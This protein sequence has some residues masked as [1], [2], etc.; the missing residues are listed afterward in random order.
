MWSRLHTRLCHPT[1]GAARVVRGAGVLRVVRHIVRLEDTPWLEVES[2][3][4]P[5]LPFGDAREALVVGG[6]HRYV[7]LG[8]GAVLDL[9]AEDRPTEQGGT[10]AAVGLEGAV[11]VQV[12]FVARDRS[13]GIER[14]R[15]EVDVFS[16]RRRLGLVQERGNRCAVGNDHLDVVDLRIHAAEGIDRELAIRHGHRPGRLREHVAGWAFLMVHSRDALHIQPLLGTACLVRAAGVPCADPYR[17][18]A[19][20]YVHL[21]RTGRLLHVRAR[22]RRRVLHEQHRVEL[23]LRHQPAVASVDR[24]VERHVRTVRRLGRRSA[25]SPSHIP[26]RSRRAVRC[27]WCSA[28]GPARCRAGSSGGRRPRPGA[29]CRSSPRRH[30]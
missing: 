3:S 26:G 16:H 9:A 18:G 5:H 21:P 6:A 7:E 25:E 13:V 14:R 27:P 29:W 28:R 19:V 1:V 20:R 23:L 11:A 22:V 17:V 10:R 8:G 2:R 15:A 4:E 24:H 30:P 12:P